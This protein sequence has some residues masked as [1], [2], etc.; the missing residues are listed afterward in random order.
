VYDDGTEDFARVVLGADLKMAL[1]VLQGAVT[2]SRGSAER[3][4]T[5]D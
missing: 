4:R 3:I 5:C 1:A 2:K